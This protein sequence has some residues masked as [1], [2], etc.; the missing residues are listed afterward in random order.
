MTTSTLVMP[1]GKHKGT[2]ITELKPSYVNW[3]LTLDSLNPDLR[4]NLEALVAE[5]ERAFQ[6]RKALAI[7]LQSSNI[8]LHERRAFKKRMGWVGA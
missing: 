8:P 7:G 6:R 3:L 5:R 2:A 1:F 4:L